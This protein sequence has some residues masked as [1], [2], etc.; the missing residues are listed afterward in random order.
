MVH[1]E[2]SIG[3]FLV[4]Y[5]RS[6]RAEMPELVHTNLLAYNCSRGSY[7]VTG[8]HFVP[9]K[10]FRIRIVCQEYARNISDV[11][12]IDLAACFTKD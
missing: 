10:Y 2:G 12:S 9:D 6:E 3:T 4:E 7:S 5:S 1:S 11:M 8:K